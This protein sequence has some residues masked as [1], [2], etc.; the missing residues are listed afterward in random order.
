MNAEMKM[1]EILA[2]IDALLAAGNDAK[3]EKA[4]IDAIR[5]YTEAHPDN[6]VGQSVLLNELGGFY[7][8]RGVYDK[9]EKAY[10]KAKELLEEIHEYASIVDEP[11]TFSGCY[12]CNIQHSNDT[13]FKHG[14]DEHYIPDVVCKDQTRTENYATTLNNLAGLYRLDQQLQK[15]ADTFDAAIS[16]Y[17]NCEGAV[18]ADHFASVYNN[19]GLLFLDQQDAAEARA[20]FLRAKE[21]LENGGEYPLALG[22]TSFNLGFA[23]IMEKQYDEAAE[24]FKEAKILFESVDAKEMVKKCEG[25]LSRLV[26]K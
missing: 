5:E 8:S 24:Y 3:T 17:E 14:T 12:A 20:M 2:G 11:A 15:A 4:L 26:T 6:T 13:G 25:L 7:R 23:A 9:G 1:D 19:K 21:L 18:N 22:T 10:L 16:V